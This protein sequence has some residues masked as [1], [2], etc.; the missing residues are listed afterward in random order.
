MRKQI[1]TL[2]CRENHGDEA[3]YILLT[4]EETVALFKDQHKSLVR[5]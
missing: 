2:K 5:L 1:D 3:E 4:T